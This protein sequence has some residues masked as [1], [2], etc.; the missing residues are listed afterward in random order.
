MS[1][2]SQRFPTS[3]RKRYIKLFP[4]EPLPPLKYD[5]D[6]DHVS[7]IIYQTLQSDKPCMITRFGSVELGCIVN[8][9]GVKNKNVLDYIRGKAEPWWWTNLTL[10]DMR[11]NAGFFSISDKNLRKFSSL[12]IQDMAQ[13]DILASWLLD[14]NKFEK[15]LSHVY[16]IWLEYLNPYWSKEPWSRALKGKKVLVVHPFVDSIQKQYQRKTLLHKHPDTLPNFEL[17]TIKAVQSIGGKCN[18]GFRDWFEALEYMKAEID[19]TD[20]DICILGCGAYGFP[21]AAHVK[22]MG[23]KAIHMGGATQ[24]LFGIRGKRW[25]EEYGEFMNEH[26]IRPSKEETPEVAIKIENGCY[27]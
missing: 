22:R 23:K 25:E 11:I 7:D 26:W 1:K 27:W 21:L 2:F 13:I 8:Y 24:M 18:E 15:E 17:K 3:I 14:E 19:K 4:S 9:L 5:M 6:A 12:M 20:Y 16:K 10:H